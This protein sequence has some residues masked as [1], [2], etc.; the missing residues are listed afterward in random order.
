MPKDETIKKWNELKDINRLADYFK[1]SI[2][3]ASIRVYKLGLFK[4]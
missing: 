3:V 1:V 2:E 4:Y